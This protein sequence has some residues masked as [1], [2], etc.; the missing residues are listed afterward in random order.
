[1]SPNITIRD[2]SFELPNGQVLFKN[3]SF[4]LG[5][6][7]TALVGPNGIGKTCLARILAGQLEP[8]TGSVRSHIPMIFFSQKETAPPVTVDEFLMTDYNWSLFGESLLQSIDRQTL[9]ADLSGG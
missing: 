7:I 1:M 9:C 8:T 3:I 4:S 5:N 6:K 2:L